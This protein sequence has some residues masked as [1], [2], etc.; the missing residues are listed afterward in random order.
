MKTHIGA[1]F[2]LVMLLAVS[3]CAF[4]SA[5]IVDK[6]VLSSPTDPKKRV[7]IFSTMHLKQFEERSFKQVREIQSSMYRLPEPTMCLVLN[8]FHPFLKSTSFSLK[9][10]GDKVLAK[11]FVLSRKNTSLRHRFENVDFRFY[12]TYVPSVENEKKIQ[13]LIKNEKEILRGYEV[14]DNRVEWPFPLS[15]EIVQKLGN[16][17]LNTI[18]SLLLS[19]INLIKEHV[20]SIKELHHKSVQFQLQQL[21]ESYKTMEYRFK[22]LFDW[23]EMQIPFIQLIAELYRNLENNEKNLEKIKLCAEFSYT[24]EVDFY[25]I[26][27]VQ[28]VDLE[29]LYK[30]YSYS[31]DMT[32]ITTGAFHGDNILQLLK[33]LGWKVLQPPKIDWEAERPHILVIPE[34][35][36]NLEVK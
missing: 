14:V 21:E 11:M 25:P 8:E 33:D 17:D 2:V 16:P 35:E 13:K 30:L 36:C 18:F 34:E 31:Y 27:F 15:Q 12:S 9:D 3:Q 19:A 7:F 4:L 1:F 10:W 29:M 23:K 26:T 24:S 28:L 20:A 6:A 5:V 22:K 32:I